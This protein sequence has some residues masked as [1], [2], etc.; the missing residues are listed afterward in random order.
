MVTAFRLE[1]ISVP[2]LGLAVEEQRPEKS[3]FAVE[4]RGAKILE[5][6]ERKGES[7]KSLR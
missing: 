3:I 4:E 2:S 1:T 6:I 5:Q 7:N